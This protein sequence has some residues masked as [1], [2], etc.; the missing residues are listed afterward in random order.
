MVTVVMNGL[1]RAGKT[2]T[3]ERLVGLP[4]KELS[5]STGVVEPSLKVTITKL[6]R[7]SAMISGGQWALLSL[8][9]ESLHL[10]ET[11]LQ[12]AGNLRP[13]SQLASL[14]TRVFKRTTNPISLPSSSGA[15]K[16][17]P[18]SQST[19]PQQ[20]ASKAT[21]AEM[22]QSYVSPPD[23]LV[24]ELLLKQW[25]KLHT[26]LE[27]ATTIHFIDTGGQP[28]FQEILPALLSGHSISMLLFKLH[29]KLNQRYQVEY[30]S[31][32]GTKS[33]P[34]MT[35]YTVGEVLFQSLATVACYGSDAAKPDP[36]QCGSV[37]LLVG[38]H[39]DKASQDDIQAAEKSLKEKIEN[40]E[41][42]EKNMV[43][44]PFSGKLIF[45]IDNTQE[46]DVQE[47]RKVLEEI[48]SKR[49]PRL[50]LSAPWLLF[51]IALRKAG[52]KILT[53]KDCQ[54]IAK[55][56][57]ITSKKE[58]KE[59][60]RFL[61]QMGM[62]RYYPD[63]KE[64][65][66]LII[67]DL[68]ILFDSITDIIVHTFTF[69]E[70]GEAGKQKFQKTGRFS[71]QE[72]KRLATQ[73]GSN[74]LLTPEKLVKLLEYL[75]ILV[76]IPEAD[77]YFMPCVLQTAD[78]DDA[79]VHSLHYPPLVI[80]FECGY[81]PV[82][83][84]SAL[85]VYLLQHSQ[86]ESSTLKWKIPNRVTVHRNKISFLVG[87]NL[88]K[89]T[90]IA[91]PT[92]LEV[93]YDCERSASQLQTPVHTVCSHIRKTILDGL[94]V[95]IRSRN[96]TCKTTPLIGFYCPRPQCTPTP[97]H[98]AVCEGETPSAMECISS[99]EPIA[100]PSSHFIWFG[101][102]SRIRIKHPPWSECPPPCTGLI[103]NVVRA[104]LC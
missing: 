47:L 5:P 72:F 37:A 13:R 91:R 15:S 12:A 52:V 77:E 19:S 80:S 35:S 48:I 17:L 44:Y 34:Y 98:I 30:V 92:Y 101:K 20:N 33:E 62:V 59:A 97:P 82:G 49:F 43:H 31:G 6:P 100:M 22:S 4:L 104:H 32:D 40:A 1:P 84:F 64:V 42:F 50:P 88:D 102:V 70:A 68:Q 93:Q 56:Y 51:E 71:L 39:K 25:D 95:V 53:M 21:T 66:D 36:T 65:K 54:K 81:C 87:D 99:K 8:D 60:L 75:H 14:F 76:S 57:G 7:S 86:E 3:K 27:D 28:E 63:V 18:P 83:I 89:V 96:Y 74:D 10:V 29:E 90:M 73:K 103:R 11:I 69:K 38:T 94:T 26:S 67:C 24:D 9:D 46:G 41:Y 45:A 23:Q 78:L 2:T 58:L 16:Q 85:I 61:H 55:C 79:T